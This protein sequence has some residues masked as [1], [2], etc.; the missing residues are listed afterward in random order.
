LDSR[1]YLFIIGWIARIYVDS[2]S[3]NDPSF[4]YIK[5]SFESYTH[6][7]IC[8]A[9]RALESRGMNVD[10]NPTLWR[11]LPLLDPTTKRIMSRDTDSLVTDREV[12]AVN[13]W[14][15]SKTSFHIMRDNWEHCTSM[16]AGFFF[17]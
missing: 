17:L 8:N 6:V 11:F 15:E 10:V 16:L 9:T 7:D 13:E 3:S 1:I 12:G 4:K 14:I 2:K 5:D